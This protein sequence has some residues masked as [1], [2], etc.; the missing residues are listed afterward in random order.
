MT[1]EIVRAIKKSEDEAEKIIADSV[2]KSREMISEA[3]K[4]KNDILKKALDDAEKESA[5]LLA[6]MDISVQKEIDSII[7]KAYE[8]GQVMRKQAQVKLSRAVNI[9]MERII[10]DHG[11]N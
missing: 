3:E 8:D 11:N 9:V 6:D 5:Q 4:R 2:L 10:K 7:K 1:L